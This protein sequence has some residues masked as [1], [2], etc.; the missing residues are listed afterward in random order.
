M[1]DFRDATFEGL[2]SQT[3]GLEE[4]GDRKKWTAVLNLERD[5]LKQFGRQSAGT[6]NRRFL[7]GLHDRKGVQQD[8]GVD[9]KDGRFHG[10]VH[11]PSGTA[12]WRIAAT[13]IPNRLSIAHP[14]I[15]TAS[16][17]A[18]SG[19]FKRTMQCEASAARGCAYFTENRKRTF[20]TTECKFGYQSVLTTRKALRMVISGLS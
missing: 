4:F 20:S 8:D 15:F 10:V 16:L 2:A 9:S 11:G 5:W 12:I 19:K 3:R 13:S 14:G 17:V 6:I 18:A 7:G 1:F